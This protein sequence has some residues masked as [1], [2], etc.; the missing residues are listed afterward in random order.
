MTD[1]NNQDLVVDLSNGLTNH[2]LQVLTGYGVTKK[3]AALNADSLSSV[4]S[5][6]K[7]FTEHPNLMCQIQALPEG[8][9]S[10]FDEKMRRLVLYP[11]QQPKPADALHIPVKAEIS[12]LPKNSPP[13][14]LWSMMTALPDTLLTH[15]PKE[16]SF[17]LVANLH[18]VAHTMMIRDQSR[19]EKN[20]FWEELG[21]D[22]FAFQVMEANGLGPK[23]KSAWISARYLGL[24]ASTSRNWFAPLLDAETNGETPPK[25]NDVMAA[26]KTIQSKLLAEGSRSLSWGKRF[27][28]KFFNNPYITWKRE[29]IQK[30]PSQGYSLLRTIIEQGAFKKNPLA[31]TLAHKILDAAETFSPNLTRHNMAAPSRPYGHHRKGAEHKSLTPKS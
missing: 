23:D 22:R 13:K 5:I 4:T 11:Y 10:F 16:A 24:L 31:E 26:V 25:H 6:T 2:A 27:K 28:L 14:V 18:E 15:F 1:T 19:T 21:C 8:Q 20:R 30:N 9:L 3:D 29:A 17:S 7:C 12:V